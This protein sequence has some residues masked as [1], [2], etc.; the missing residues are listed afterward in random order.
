MGLTVVGKKQRGKSECVEEQ[1]QVSEAAGASKNGTT[2]NELG[3][4]K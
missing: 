2:E 1:Q 3:L 4:R